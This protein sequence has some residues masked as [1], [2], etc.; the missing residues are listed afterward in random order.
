MK[1]IAKGGTEMKK[2]F[3]NEG[4]RLTDCC[5]DYSVYTVAGRNGATGLPA[6]KGCGNQVLPGEGDGFEINFEIAFGI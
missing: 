6:C 1:Q 2:K 3:D 4:T 5:G